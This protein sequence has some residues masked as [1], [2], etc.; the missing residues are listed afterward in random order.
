MSLSKSKKSFL[1]SH[2]WKIAAILLV[3]CAGLI[4]SAKSTAPTPF[5]LADNFPRGAAVYL[6]FKDLPALIKQWNGSDLKQ[7]LFASTNYQQFL[8]RHLAIKIAARWNEFNSALG[9]DLDADAINSSVDNRAAVA[10]YDI[11]R[12]DFIFIIPLSEEKIA[13]SKFFQQKDHFEETE[14]DDGTVFYS[15]DVDADR[16]RQKQKIEFAAQNGLLVVATNEQIFLR[17]LSNINGKNRQDRLSA[18][19]NFQQLSS[20]M[21]PHFA[22]AWVDQTKLNSD[23]Y[24][25]H[26]WVMR[27]IENLADM[28]A[29]MFDL[30]LQDGK[31]IEHREFLINGKAPAAQS[32]SA[33]DARRIAELIPPDLP[34]WKLAADN[35][36]AAIANLARNTL[37]N[38]DPA[39]DAKKGGGKRQYYDGG[40]F[41]RDEDYS[42]DDSDNYVYLSRDYN[43]TIDNARDAGID[44]DAGFDDSELREQAERKFA[45][46]LQQIIAP[47]GPRLTVRAESL[48]SIAGPLFAEDRKAAIISLR[49]PGQLNRQALESAIGE[50]AGAQLMLVGANVN[51]QWANS[52][53]G[54]F[55]ELILP[56]L[57]SRVCYGI[58]GQELIIANNFELLGSILTDKRSSRAVEINSDNLSDLTVIKFDQGEAAFA[59]IFSKLDGQQIEDYWRSHSG[60][61]NDGH[62]EEFFSGNIASLL[63]VASS[64]NE[65]EIV[66]N[67]RPGRLHED[68]VFS[69]KQSVAKN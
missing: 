60:K 44:N 2:L 19:P 48:N 53:D 9:F 54:K 32:I 36:G 46:R 45:A 66:R 22:T 4:V 16:G 24:F 65:I 8:H 18:D 35:S 43:L 39:S 28:R 11:G 62:S 14:L 42:S 51:L 40:D 68:I 23:W 6:Q 56:L 21:K 34:Y 57:N 58:K 64:I 10:L 30:E 59:Q 25:R 20:Q 61:K 63:S 27:N 31:W 7:Q 67:A 38:G 12:L 52:N 5:A 50:L 33:Q 37:F 47:A 3:I 26:Y 15:I 49:A 17:A 55:R 13:A 69:L 29:G 41:S 1:R